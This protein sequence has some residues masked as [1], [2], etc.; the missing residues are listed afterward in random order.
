LRD[1]EREA[2][3]RLQAHLRQEIEIVFAH[4]DNIGAEAIQRGSEIAIECRI[5]EGDLRSVCTKGSRTQ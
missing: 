2:P 3:V 4:G 1:F 5:E